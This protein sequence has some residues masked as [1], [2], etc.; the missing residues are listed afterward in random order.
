[1]KVVSTQ[2]MRQMDR[3]AMEY[4]HIPGVVLMEH[5]ALAVKKHIDKRE[6]RQA[7]IVILCGPGNNGGDGFALARLLV[8]DGYEQVSIFCN[9]EKSKQSQDEQVFSSMCEAYLIPMYSC[10]AIED[11]KGL[12]QSAAIIIDALFGTGLTREITGFYADLITYV[13]ELDKQVISIDIASGVHGD[14]AQVMGCAL[15]AAETIS[16]ECYKQGLILYPGS[17]YCGQVFIE[18][19]AMPKDIVEASE[20][21]A[22]IDHQIVRSF[23][24]KRSSHS[25][26][27][28]YGKALMIGGSMQMHGAITLAAKAALYSGIGTLTLAVPDGIHSILAGKLEECML[29]PLPME[30]GYCSITASELLKPMLKQYDLIIIG[31]GLGRS[32]GAQALVDLVLSSDLP[33]ILDGDALYL[34]GDHPALKTRTAPAILTPHIKEMSYLSKVEIGQI[35]QDPLLMLEQYQREHSQVCIVLKDEHTLVHDGQH[36]YLN[37][38]GNHA[39]AK[40]GSGDVLCGMLA[41]LFGQSKKPLESAVSAVYVHALAADHLVERKSAFSIQPSDILEELSSIYQ[42]LAG[43]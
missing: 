22:V 31:N 14:T 4:Y 11:I 21:V 2:T 33:C 20:G 43:E 7:A 18:T 39:L 40:G 5:A 41:G 13:N 30:D 3:V 6:D 29:I 34:A 38:A 26:K 1:M 15:R 12:L 9:V 32:A 27:G 25:H 19:I 42:M 16:F 17:S 8:Q 36:C 35:L 23:L 24:P 10:A 28:S 37:L